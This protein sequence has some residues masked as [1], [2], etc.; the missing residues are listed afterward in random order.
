MNNRT[1]KLHERHN[2]RVKL[3]TEKWES[4]TLERLDKIEIST[5]I[6]A[7]YKCI[8]KDIDGFLYRFTLV[9]YPTGYR[10]YN[11]NKINREYKE[12]G[13]YVSTREYSIVPKKWKKIFNELI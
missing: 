3:E 13:Q 1:L 5:G 7:T 11:V 10:T 12:Y 2:E 4:E 8:L 9:T 6:N